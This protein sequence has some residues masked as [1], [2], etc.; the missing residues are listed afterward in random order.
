[1]KCAACGGDIADGVCVSC[2]AAVE[3]VTEETTPEMEVA[4]EVVTEESAEE[5]A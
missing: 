3:T 2:G 1:M 5:T 4:G